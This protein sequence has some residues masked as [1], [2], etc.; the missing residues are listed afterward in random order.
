MFL[1]VMQITV[2]KE[3]RW[4]TWMPA[5]NLRM[6]FHSITFKSCQTFRESHGFRTCLLV[7]VDTSTFYKHFLK[8]YG[9][10]AVDGFIYIFYVR[11]HRSGLNFRRAFLF[12]NW[13]NNFLTDLELFLL[14]L[15]FARFCQLPIGSLCLRISFLFLNA[16]HMRK[17][18]FFLNV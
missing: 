9:F 11:V 15:V 18:H 8:S 1:F 7:F 10:L 5:T 3:E 12:W 2:A 13:N 6:G 4:L 14:A 16:A 17:G